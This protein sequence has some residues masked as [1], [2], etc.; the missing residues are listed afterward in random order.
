MDPRPRPRPGPVPGAVAALLL[1]VPV[2]CL[3]ALARAEPAPPASAQ[4]PKPHESDANWQTAPATRR[5]GFTA[6]LILAG[7]LG[8]ASGTP[9]D[10]SKIGDPTY[11][12]HTGGIGPG[13]ALWIGGALTDWFTFGL[14]V[15]MSSFGGSQLSSKSSVFLFHIEAFPLFARGGVYRDLGVFADFGTGPGSIARKSTKEEISSAGSFSVAGIGAFWETWRFAGFAAGPVVAWQYQYSQPLERHFA[16]VG[17]RGVFY[18][19]P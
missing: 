15:G 16:L 3:P 10:Y 13:G 2:L 5:S 1:A 8:Y 12:S 11:T 17:L 18:G 14:G 4:A 6:G 9:N 19:G 7:A